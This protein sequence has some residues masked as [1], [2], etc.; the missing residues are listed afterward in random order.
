MSIWV[1]LMACLHLM[2]GTVFLGITIASYF[3]IAQAK[4]D[5]KLQAYALKASLLG[6]RLVVVII[7]LEY[8]TATGMVKAHHLAFSTPWIVVAYIAF[9]VIVLC[10]VGN[11]CLKTK[12]LK[13]GQPLKGSV[14]FHVLHIAMIVIFMM[15]I[16]DAVMQHTYLT[17]LFQGAHG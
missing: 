12:A 9:S 6:D 5:L 2:C 7:V 1:S 14:L 3:Y 17:F 13:A 10:W 8:L 11:V 4:A 16:H 15:V